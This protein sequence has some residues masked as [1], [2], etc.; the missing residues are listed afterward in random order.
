MDVDERVTIENYELNPGPH[1]EF[2]GDDPSLVKTISGEVVRI[3]QPLD[4]ESTRA[5]LRDL[6]NRGLMSVAICYLHSHIFP[7]H[8]RLTAQIAQ[9]EG[10]ESV[11][12]SAEISPRIKILPRITGVCTDAYL[13]PVVS[14]YVN[15]FLESFDTPP[16][17]VDFIASDGGLRKAQLYSGNAALLSGPAGG[18]VGI[19][20]SCY[21]LKDPKAL[22]GF[23]MVCHTVR[24]AQQYLLTCIRVAPA[25][26]SLDMMANLIISST[27]PLQVERSLRPCL[28]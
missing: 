13:S 8:E 27:R 4:V 11:S 20:R 7:D 21:D 14:T 6:R 16:Q 28:M 2:D 15:G 25:Q 24:F 12:W 18:V 17:R 3:L 9:E 10:F 5:S 26:M 1:P 23:D 22:I 19:A